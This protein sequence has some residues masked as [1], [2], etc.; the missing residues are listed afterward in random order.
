MFRPRNIDVGKPTRRTPTKAAPMTTLTIS[1][2]HDEAL[3]LVRE[4]V[5][6]YLPVARAR[7]VEMD[8]QTWSLVINE[9]RDVVAKTA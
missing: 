9:V 8:P 7:R 6:A 1:D 4:A 2:V 3:A 5:T